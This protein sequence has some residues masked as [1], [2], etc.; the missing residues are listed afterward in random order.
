MGVSRVFPSGG[1]SES[2]RQGVSLIVLMWKPKAPTVGGG[3][4]V[5]AFANWRGGCLAPWMPSL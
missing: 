3:D 5:R 1:K 2:F 4:W